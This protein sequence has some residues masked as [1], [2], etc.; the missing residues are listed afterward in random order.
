MNNLYVKSVGFA[1]QINGIEDFF[2]GKQLRRMDNF[3][4]LVLLAAAK[5][6]N[7]IEVSFKEEKEDIGL[8][9]ASG[10]GP[11][12]QTCNFMDSIINDGD[13]LAS[14]LAFSASVHNSLETAVTNLLNLRGPCLTLS[15]GGGTFA[16]AISTAKSWLLSQRCKTVL[17]G[18]ADEIHPVIYKEY[19]H[20]IFHP[21]CAA[22]FLLSL[23]E[24]EY[25]FDFEDISEDNFNPALPAFTM[26]KQYIPLVNKKDVQRIISDFIKTFLAGKKSDILSVFEN[27]DMKEMLKAV[28][29]I[30]REGIYDGLSLLC[31]VDIKTEIVNND[32]DIE[33]IC[34]KAFLKNKKINFFTS[35]STGTPKSCFHSDAMIKEEVE[36][37]SFLF[38]GIKRVV[39]T[40][41]S[42]HSYGFVFGLQLPKLNNLSFITNPPLPFLEWENILRDGDLFIVFPLFLKYLVETDF[43]FPKGVTILTS[44]AP[45]PDSLFEEVYKRGAQK[46]IE[47]YGSSETGAIGFRESAGAPFFLLPFW[48]YAEQGNTIIDISR[49]KTGLKSELPDIVRTKGER[50]FS[51]IERKDSAVQ[52][53]GVNVFPSKVEKILKQHFAVKEAAVRLG[54]ERLKAFIV[55]RSDIDVKKAKKSIQKYIQTVLTSH[56]IPKNITFGDELP[57]T[58]LG[59][60]SDW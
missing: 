11:V 37:L 29:K 52:V 24:T 22:F 14:P 50:L 10:R 1:E 34:L 7:E 12:K 13:E 36:G 42:H 26:V 23:E 53:A 32:T 5:T 38:S 48:D 49:K 59:K 57:V 54:E 28:N 58:T 56:E 8:I 51:V 4:K 19:E 44:T 6:L 41:P 47:I 16:S 17:L 31:D 25:K 20:K 3:T 33:D 45:C 60:K 18:V 2:E 15:Q 39:T 35:G 30:D 9:I 55:L 46:I 27:P 43:V 21:E 40:L